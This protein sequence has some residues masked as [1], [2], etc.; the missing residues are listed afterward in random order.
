[1]HE[2][3]AHPAWPPLATA[4]AI[5]YSQLAGFYRMSCICTCL[6]VHV[7]VCSCV[8]TCVFVGMCVCMWAMILHTCIQ[9]AWLMC[10]CVIFHAVTILHITFY[11]CAYPNL[12]LS[13]KWTFLC[14][15]IP[16]KR[17]SSS[18]GGS[19]QIQVSPCHNWSIWMHSVMLSVNY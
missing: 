11:A 3:V 12:G 9:I 7:H 19:R 6:H 16:N 13:S 1:M 10:A 4:I 17:T 14:S 18:P 5:F 8:C 15:T 2:L